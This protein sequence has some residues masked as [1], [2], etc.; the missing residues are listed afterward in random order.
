MSSVSDN[1]ISYSCSFSHSQ[2]LLQITYSFH[3]SDCFPDTQ[4]PQSVERH[5]YKSPPSILDT[6]SVTRLSTYIFAVHKSTL[7]KLSALFLL[8]SFIFSFRDS[9]LQ[10]L[11]DIVRGTLQKIDRINPSDS[12]SSVSIRTHE[13]I[14]TSDKNWMFFFRNW[15][16]HENEIGHGGCWRTA[17][18]GNELQEFPTNHVIVFYMWQQITAFDV[19]LLS[20]VGQ[21]DRGSWENL[22]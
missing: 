3:L 20:G 14:L 13:R 9:T 1:F 11:M 6:K 2:Q 19:N 5:S 17:F 12:S 22:L 8:L 15:V 10:L 4:T 16:R 21:A 7:C 18:R